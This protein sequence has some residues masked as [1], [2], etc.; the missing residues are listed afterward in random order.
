MEFA[1]VKLKVNVLK[2]KDRL[3]SFGCI[4]FLHSLIANFFLAPLRPACPVAGKPACPVA[5]RP[6]CCEAGRDGVI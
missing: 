3:K 5:G 2:I 4:P 1:I 6:A